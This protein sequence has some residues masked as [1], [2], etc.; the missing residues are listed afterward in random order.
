MTEKEIPETTNYHFLGMEIRTK[1]F[2]ENNYFT[3][4]QG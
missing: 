2:L 3:L 4:V 1:L